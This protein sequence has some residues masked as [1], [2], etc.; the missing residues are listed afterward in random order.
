MHLAPSP[1]RQRGAPGATHRW[2]SEVRR[3]CSGLVAKYLSSYSG[4]DKP[5]LL[6]KEEVFANSFFPKKEV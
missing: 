2:C 5:L 3:W 4:R 1:E 6:T